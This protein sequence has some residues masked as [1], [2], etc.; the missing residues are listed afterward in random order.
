MIVMQS[1]QQDGID[2][3]ERELLTAAVTAVSYS[4]T[5]SLTEIVGKLQNKRLRAALMHYTLA[6]TY[7]HLLD[8]NHDN[9]A[10]NRFITFDL[11]HL[12]SDTSS[13]SDQIIIPVLMHIFRQIEKRL[14]GRPTLVIL[15]EGW[16][17][18]RHPLVAARFEEWIRTLRQYNA[19][20]MFGTQSVADIENSPLRHILFESCK[21]KIYLPN[22]DADTPAIRPLYESLGLNSREIQIIKDATPKRHYYCVS[23]LGRR[24]VSFGLGPVTLAFCG[25]T[26]QEERALVQKM[27]NNNPS[28]WQADWLRARGLP[29]WATY[30]EETQRERG[31][32]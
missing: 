25:A 1:K 21:T 27:M 4:P 2:P 30:Y 26:S 28:G 6:G 5:P 7:G 10:S 16:R 13:T 14:D 9:L 31:A 32:A 19:G 8:A 29:D 12:L 23:P 3:N 24:L 20:V 17:H 11:H 22:I 15:D 18:I